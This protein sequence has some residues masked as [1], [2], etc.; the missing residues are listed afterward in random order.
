MKP[1]LPTASLMRSSQAPL[2]SPR[3]QPYIADHQP[4]ADPLVGPQ[5]RVQTSVA[6]CVG[7]RYLAALDACGGVDILDGG[8]PAQG[9][10]MLESARM[11]SEHEVR[12]REACHAGQ[13]PEQVRQ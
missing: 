4:A 11:L 1:G 3:G 6:T 13:G 12:A 2:A 8:Q 5:G 10:E 9:A 7:G